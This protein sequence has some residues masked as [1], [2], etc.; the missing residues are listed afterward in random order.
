MNMKQISKEECEII[1]GHCYVEGSSVPRHA[2]IT[3]VYHKHYRVCKHCGH[4]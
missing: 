1:G 2:E 3:I 4:K